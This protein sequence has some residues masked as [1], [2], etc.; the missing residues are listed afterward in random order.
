MED[1][2][3][4]VKIQEILP[5]RFPFLLVDRVLEVH[6][7]EDEET[8]VGR[9]IKALKNVTIG[10]SHFVGH[11]PKKPVMPGVL[12]IEAMAQAGALAFFDRARGE[13]DVAIASVNDAKFRKP[14]VPGDTLILEAEIKKYRRNMVVIVCSASV[15]NQRVAE[16]EIM[17]YVNYRE[18]IN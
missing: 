9:K 15:D 10:E 11:F 18:A 12:I 14:V 6:A 16:A 2:W 7:G 17:A 3:D 1:T 8:R 4:V 5:H 13:A